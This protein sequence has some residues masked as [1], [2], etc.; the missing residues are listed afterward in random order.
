[1]AVAGGQTEAS[2]DPV[3]AGSLLATRQMAGPL[4]NEAQ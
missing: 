1:M 3:L 2:G 4:Q